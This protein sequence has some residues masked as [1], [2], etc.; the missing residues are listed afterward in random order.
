MLLIIEL[1][2]FLN[3]QSHSSQAKNLSHV[4]A[5]ES[6]LFSIVSC[7]KTVLGAV[8]QVYKDSIVVGE[9]SPCD[10]LFS[11]WMGFDMS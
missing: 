8:W 7:D 9:D 4:L 10:S 2:P 6:C 11:V 1:T 5:R 3:A